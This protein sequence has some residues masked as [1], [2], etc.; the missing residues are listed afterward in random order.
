MTAPKNPAD[1]VAAALSRSGLTFA[2]EPRLGAVATDFLV[3]TPSGSLAYVETKGW[4]PTPD[5]TLRAGRQA[6][7]LRRLTGVPSYIVLPS[8]RN[9]RPATSV[10]N[11]TGLVDTL[12]AEKA[13][14]RRR[15]GVR[16][17]RAKSSA[18]KPLVFAA[19][20]FSEDYDDVFYVAIA[21]A[22]KAAGAIA[23]RIDHDD[24]DGDT[25]AAIQAR[26]HKSTVVVADLSEVRLNVL[27]ETGFAHALNRQTVH[28]C[29]TNL[30]R[31]P[32][33]VRNWNTLPYKK[34]QTHK[35][36]RAL[37]RRIR[38]A[39]ARAFHGRARRRAA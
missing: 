38:L 39:L 27:Y 36:R 26:I 34:G 5:A 23:I 7:Y 1:L 16:L 6:A 19:M 9:S 24:F 10:F 4:D 32:F 18:P 15:K 37:I 8:L 29:S 28:I 20:P 35:L 12:R 21:P 31:L 11:V 2:R 3:K 33:D 14:P 25:V 17:P 13:E 30:R 22:A